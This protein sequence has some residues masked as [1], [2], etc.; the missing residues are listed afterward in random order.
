MTELSKGE[1]GE[2]IISNFVDNNFSK[3]FSFSSP[4]TKNNAEIAD[5]LIWL[6][7]TVFLIEVKTRNTDEGNA[8]IE[9]WAYSQ[10]KKAQ[11]QI[12][13]NVQRIKAQEEIFLHN[14]Y[15]HSKLD[16]DGI[17]RVIAIIVLVHEEACKITPSKYQKNLYTSKVPI[18]VISWT[19][20]QKISNEIETIADLQY[21]FHDRAE[22]LKIQDIN[23]DE[24]LNVVGYYKLHNNK[25]PTIKT[26]FS[27]N[28]YFDNYQKIMQS[29]IDARNTHNKNS[30]WIENIENLFKSQRKLMVGIPIGLLFAW[31]LG[32]LSQRERAYY[33]EKINTVQQWF[34]D[35]N[36]ER[37]FSYKSQNTGNW[38]L[39]H[40]TTLKKDK[41]NQRLEDLTK[42]KL[43]KEIEDNTFEFG[44]YSIC[45]NVSNIYPHQLEVVGGAVMST[46]A[47]EGNYDANDIEKAAKLFG[48]IKAVKIEEFPRSKSS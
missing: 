39:F 45:F 40:F 11:S 12:E 18:H 19:D 33:G 14:D 26:D 13:K 35:G 4:K 42:L 48:K 37:F 31:E 44:I 8:P 3:I 34:N 9:S 6:N 20:L 1:I 7:R 2:Q 36:T 17:C 28:D 41:A 16:C 15:Y 43:I 5:V 10:I 25:F 32:R 29:E 47:V 30:S 38:L 23:L 21:Y 22:Y 27:A 46:D 24:E